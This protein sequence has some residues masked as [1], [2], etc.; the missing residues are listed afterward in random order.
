MF[1]VTRKTI[2]EW[3]DRERKDKI[4]H[5]E[6]I[7]EDIEDMVRTVEDQIVLGA[8]NSRAVV[9]ESMAGPSWGKLVLEGI[10]RLIV[11]RG[12]DKDVITKGGKVGTVQVRISIGSAD[13]GV[14]IVDAEL[15]D[16]DE[17]DP[18]SAAIDAPGD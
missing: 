6:Q 10:D 2:Y 8:R 12:L 15:V 7:D 9:P 11:L 1:G 3:I 14:Q 4:A 5:R 13:P 17:V 16:E 18:L